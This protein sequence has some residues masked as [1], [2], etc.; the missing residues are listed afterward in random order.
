MAEAITSRGR[1][2]IAELAQL[3]TRLIDLNPRVVE[4]EVSLDDVGLD[5]T[6]EA[7]AA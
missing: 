6:E 5:G 4:G 1:I 3:S 2:A 7:V